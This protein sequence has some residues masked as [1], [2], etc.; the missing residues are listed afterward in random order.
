M[1]VL[2][3]VLDTA[4]SKVFSVEKLIFRSSFGKTCS[5]LLFIELSLSCKFS[6]LF[7]AIS[8]VTIFLGLP[9]TPLRVSFFGLP[10]L[11]AD[12]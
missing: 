11:L 2:S 12:D 9:P 7:C 6:V 3:L 1:E 5:V 8:G 4:K 10:R